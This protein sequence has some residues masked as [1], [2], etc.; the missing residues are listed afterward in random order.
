MEEWIGEGKAKDFTIN[1]ER[2]MEKIGEW[3]RNF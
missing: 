2:Y 1:V 3:I